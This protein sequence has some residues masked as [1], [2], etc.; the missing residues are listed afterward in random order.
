E[1]DADGS[2]QLVQIG[3]LPLTL[4]PTRVDAWLESVDMGKETLGAGMQQLMREVLR[5]QNDAR[6][7]PW[8]AALDPATS[9]PTAA[10]A[11][12][13]RLTRRVRDWVAQDR[14]MTDRLPQMVDHKVSHSRNVDRHATTLL[15][16]AHELAQPANKYSEDMFEALSCAAWLHDIGHSGGLVGGRFVGDYYHVRKVHGLLSQQHICDIASGLLPDP[17]D[18]PLALAVG[19]LA[20]HHQRFTLLTDS[21]PAHYECY[22]ACKQARCPIC[23]EVAQSTANNLQQKLVATEANLPNTRID[24]WLHLAAILRL[25][26]AADLGVHRVG[27]RFL[28][29]RAIDE[30]WRRE[31]AGRILDVLARSEGVPEADIEV[32]KSYLNNPSDD[33]GTAEPV[34][35]MLRNRGLG[36]EADRFEDYLGFLRKQHHHADRHRAIRRAAVHF[37]DN[38]DRGAIEVRFVLDQDRH[39]PDAL[40]GRAEQ[41]AEYVWREYDQSRSV[42]EDCGLHLARVAA[43]AH[44]YDADHATKA[45]WLSR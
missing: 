6:T 2:E 36:E 7:T 12:R 24:Q 31:E 33:D 45:G 23:A 8:L 21:P 40:T 43:G 14:W 3:P 37:P 18:A 10:R 9:L 11:T 41:A 44:A 4:E 16:R 30:L 27:G 35:D 32:V 5:A 25:A 34:A 13:E 15:L 29:P 26:D 17:H 19:L 42:L 38:D 39:P 1:A 20:A 28:A 22:K